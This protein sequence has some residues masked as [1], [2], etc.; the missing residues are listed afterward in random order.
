MT[1]TL[2]TS[3]STYVIIWT[4]LVGPTSQMLHTQSHIIS[5]LVL[6]KKILKG[7]PIYGHG[8]HLGK[9]TRTIWKNIPSCIL[10]SFLMKIECNWLSTFWEN[11]AL[12]YWWESNMS[13][14]GWKVRGQPW[15]LELSYI[16]S[17]CFIMLSSENSLAS[18]V[19]K[20]NF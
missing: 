20:I 18:T 19:F 10:R 6:E 9:A 12:K 15:M 11:Y 4:N 17:H 1:L 13:D 3:W 14:L 16:H 8:R 2:S 7:F 5:L